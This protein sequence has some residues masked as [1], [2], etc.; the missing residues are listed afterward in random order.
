MQHGKRQ[1]D[2]PVL[3]FSSKHGKY[4]IRRG[5]YAYVLD[6]DLNFFKLFLSKTLISP[7]TSNVFI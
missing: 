6:I 4:K 2:T 5:N 1:Q 3:P 7:Y